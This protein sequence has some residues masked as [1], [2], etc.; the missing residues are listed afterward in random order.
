MTSLLL[1]LPVELH[2]W[3][4]IEAERQGD[5]MTAR[6]VAAI[7]D[8]REHSKGGQTALDERVNTL[9]T[10]MGKGKQ[11]PR[12]EALLGILAHL[13][14]KHVKTLE[15]SVARAQKR[16]GQRGIRR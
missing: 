1:R 6:A 9:L 16:E 8:A 3:L 15:D 5:N 7:E 11:D 2:E 4:R 14:S 10:A 12:W 13:T